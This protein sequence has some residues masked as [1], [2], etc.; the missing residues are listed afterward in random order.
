MR[1]VLIGI[2]SILIVCSVYG[3]DPQ[4]SHFYAIPLQMGPAFAGSTGG[5]RVAL[6]ARDQWTAINQEYMTFSVMA[7]HYFYGTRSGGGIVLYRDQAGAGKMATSIANLQYAYSVN[8]TKKIALRG[9]LQM[10]LSHRSID[11]SRLVFGDQLRF[12]DN[13]PTTS[14]NSL[15]DSKSYLDFGASFMTVISNFWMGVTADHIIQ[16]NQSL[17]GH[18]SIVPLKFSGYAGGKFSYR[19]SPQ[20][21]R[22]MET[23]YLMLHYNE[24]DNFKQAFAGAYWETNKSILGLWYRGIPFVKA[25]ET[26]INNDALIFMLGFKKNMFTFLYSYDF[27]ISKL[28]ANTAGSHEITIT[29]NWHSSNSDKKAKRNRNMVPCPMSD[30]PKTKYY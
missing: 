11:Y 2:M 23:I 15:Y 17:M 28:V 18:E 3:Q 13:V 19:T 8:A 22:K 26:Y 14:E 20:R 29:W 7:D 12:D 10:G 30:N 27:T 16:P 25:Y 24:Q 5:T 9:G 21:G 1:G 6:N 4:F